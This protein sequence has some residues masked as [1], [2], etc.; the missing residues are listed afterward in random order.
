MLMADPQTLGQIRRSLHKEVGNRLLA[1]I[2]KNLT[3]AP[4]GDIARALSP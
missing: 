2:D 3:N 4:L 1:T